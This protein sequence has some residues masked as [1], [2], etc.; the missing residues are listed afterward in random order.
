MANRVMD[1]PPS[2]WDMYVPGTF[3]LAGFGGAALLLRSA[4]VPGT[5]TGGPGSGLVFDVGL[6]DPQR[7]VHYLRRPSN[8]GLVDQLSGFFRAA[9]A[10]EHPEST[11][12]PLQDESLGLMVYVEDST[13]ATVDL[14][15]LVAQ[16]LQAG[17]RGDDE[18]A[19]TTSRAALA[20]AALEVRWLD[21]ITDGGASG[22]EPVFWDEEE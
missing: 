21:Q 22:E 15:V 12:R 13:E 19:F 5:L 2:R 1:R 4:V 3:R 16:D 8:S 17:V 7:R 11:L 9:A 14:M 20:S 6:V 18:F 10:E